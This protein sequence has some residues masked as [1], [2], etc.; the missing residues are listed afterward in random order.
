MSSQ[1]WKG[2]ERRVCRDMGLTRRGQVTAG[3]YAKG[4]DNDDT[5]PVS[6]EIK[7]TTRYQLRRSWV[8]QARANAD[9][10]GRPW[11]LVIAEHRDSRKLAVLDYATFLILYR[12]AFA[13]LGAGK[14][15]FGTPAT[16]SVRSGL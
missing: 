4:S 8:E 3:G 6:V 12:A 1:A 5:G 16:T 7:Y 11:V 10:D 15:G 2:L 13:P 9:A 14:P